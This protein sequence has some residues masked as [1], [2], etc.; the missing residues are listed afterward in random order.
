[1]IDEYMRQ[2]DVALSLPQSEDNSSLE[3]LEKITNKMEKMTRN[4]K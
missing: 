1:M 2:R 4:E 3:R